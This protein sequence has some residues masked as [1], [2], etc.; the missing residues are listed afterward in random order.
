MKGFFV[1]ITALFLLSCNSTQLIESWKNPEIT[2]Y[3]PS[4]VFIVGLTSNAE[5]RQKFETKLKYELEIRG[6]EAVRSSDVLDQS[7][8]TNR[9][10]ESEMDALEDDLLHDGFDTVLLSKIIGVEDKIVYK[11]NYD[12]F[13]ETHKKFREDY[14]KYQD[15]FYNPDY[16]DE[17][18]IYH[19]ETS[20]HCICPTEERTLI[21]KGYIDILDPKSGDNTITNY[22]N[23]VVAV[24]EDQQLISPISFTDETTKEKVI[25]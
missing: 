10:T 23:I 9:M 15:I 22:V 17:Y 5:A 8:Q 21:W 2:S 11:E 19:A 6:I 20:M 3:A 16:Y 14:L 7:Y 25:N 4:K 12:D 1:I 13:D 18:S 24:L